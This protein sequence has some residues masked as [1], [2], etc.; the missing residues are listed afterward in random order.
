MHIEHLWL[1]DFRSYPSVDLEL[2]SGVCAVLGPNGVGKSNLLE[3]V[4]YLAL[5]ESFRGAP[6]DA[7]IRSGCASAVV[8]GAIRTDDREQLIEAELVRS[9]R[10]RVQVN[11]QR[12]TRTRDLLGA[13][14]LT[15]FSPDDLAVIKGGPSLR[16]TYLDQLLVAVNPRNDAVRSE[17]ERALRQRNA[18]LKQ[19]HGRLDDAAQ[20]TLEVWDAKVVAAGEELT[21]RRVDLVE[22]IEPVVLAA[23]RDVAG[24]AEPIVL[25]YDSTWRHTGLADALRASRPD[26][27]RRGLTL[28]GP[29]RDDVVIELNG[30]PSRTHASQG[31]Q[32]SLAL[33]LRL[34][35]HRTVHDMVGSPPVLVLDDVFSELD[36]DRSAALL[37]SLPPG[38]TLLSTAAGMPPG[39]TADQ[40][41]TVDPGEVLST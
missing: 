39:I 12:L 36:P 16:R 25:H 21:R 5:L 13:V 35:A 41:L 38:Q 17:F 9:G 33:A 20:L 27:L 14:R 28:V 19:T 10:N 18:L 24:G 15:V 8:R 37:G 29:H 7:M 34:A 4:A 26:E 2:T 6:A 40:V 3:A 23:Y 31:E 30:L 32:R 1:K 22:R 11:R